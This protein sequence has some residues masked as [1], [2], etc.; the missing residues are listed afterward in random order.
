MH[1]KTLVVD[2][3]LSCEGSYKDLICAGSYNWLSAVYDLS[4]SANNFE[5]SVG[6]RGTI[7]HKMLQI[8]QTASGKVSL[9][10]SQKR[11]YPFSRKKQSFEKFKK[12]KISPAKFPSGFEK[13]I[14]IFSGEQITKKGTVYAQW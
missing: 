1:E 9:K 11:A 7:A 10:E 12:T 13:S 6:I 5:M 3:G 8:Y 14:K 2:K 4:H